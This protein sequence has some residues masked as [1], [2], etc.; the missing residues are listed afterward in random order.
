MVNT[1]KVI[2]ILTRSLAFT[3]T[4][5]VVTFSTTTYGASS[6]NVSSADTKKE[7]KYGERRE[8][9]RE[10]EKKRESEVGQ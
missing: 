2:D 6:F 8:R 1:F 5:N 3:T 9:E 4:G 10:R 7:R